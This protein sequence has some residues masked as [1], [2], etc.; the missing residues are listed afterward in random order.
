MG[1]LKKLLGRKRSTNDEDCPFGVHAAQIYRMKNVA[2]AGAELCEIALSQRKFL[3]RGVL[4][5]DKHLISFTCDGI[6]RVATV[7]VHSAPIT[8]S[9]LVIAAVYEVGPNGTTAFIQSLRD[10]PSNYV[11]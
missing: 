7:E 6:T 1:I 4:P 11:R 8:G 9:A 3:H 2:G 10:Y 5:D